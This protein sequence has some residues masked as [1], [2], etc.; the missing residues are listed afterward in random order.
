MPES[1]PDNPGVIAP[2]PLIALGFIGLGLAAD[3]VFPAPFVSPLLASPTHYWI[4]GFLF[5]LGVAVVLLAIGQFAKAGT[6]FRTERPST[7]LLADGL[8]RYSRNPIYIA[9]SA[10]YLG[11]AIATDS[12]WVLGFIIPFLALIRQG[13]IAREERYLEAKFGDSYR[14]YTSRVRRWL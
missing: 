10:A 8:Y 5:A 12:L 6:S 11:V 4:G 7:A 14:D 2:P 13:V 1:R 3:W 9:L